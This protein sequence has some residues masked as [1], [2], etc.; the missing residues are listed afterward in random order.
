MTET[1]SEETQLFY[2]MPAAICVDVEQ[3]NLLEQSDY[4]LGGNHHSMRSYW[5][6]RTLGPDSD[7]LPGC[8]NCQWGFEA[9]GTLKDERG[10]EIGGILIL[11]WKVDLVPDVYEVTYE[12]TQTSS[13][14]LSYTWSFEIIE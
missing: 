7:S 12:Y 8:N 3:K 2:R 11:C 9:G 1:K 6:V 13:H 5:K 10:N 4:G 14:V